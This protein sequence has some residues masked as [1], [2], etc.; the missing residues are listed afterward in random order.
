MFSTIKSQISQNRGWQKFFASF[1]IVKLAIAVL[2]FVFIACLIA[3]NIGGFS[4]AFNTREIY[5]E[6]SAKILSQYENEKEAALKAY[7]KKTA[8]SYRLFDEMYS[9][10]TSK[11]EVDSEGQEE[12]V[13]QAALNA[14]WFAEKVA[15]NNA[16]YESNKQAVQS[17][18]NQK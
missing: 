7:E 13:D 14:E 12:R 15:E 17:F 3:S 11:N 8:D 4:R 5:E 16:R 18:T 10:A 6:E 2:V 9:E 1:L